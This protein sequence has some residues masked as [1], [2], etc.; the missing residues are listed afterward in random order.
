MAGECYLT[1]TID[2]QFRTPQFSLG[3]DTVVCPGETVTYTVAATN[4]GDTYYWEPGE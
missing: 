3:N 2:V 1:D 4:P